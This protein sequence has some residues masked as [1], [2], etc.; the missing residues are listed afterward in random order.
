MAKG[1]ST[2]NKMMP[3]M[4]TYGGQNNPGYEPPN[5]TAGS[6]AFGEYSYKSN[7]TKVPM[8]GSKIGPGYGNTDRM[9]AMEHKEQEA[10]KE[11]L[12]GQPC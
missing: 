10:K 2:S 7:P 9:K 3:R 11:S 12:R 8:K 5:G 4:E 1:T 6:E